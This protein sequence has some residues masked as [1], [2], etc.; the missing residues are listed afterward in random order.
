MEHTWK[1]LVVDDTPQNIKVGRSRGWWW[2][3]HSRSWLSRVFPGQWR[4]TMSWM[5]H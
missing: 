2:P 5:P 4:C 1:L 3:R